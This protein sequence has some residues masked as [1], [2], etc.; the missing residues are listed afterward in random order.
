MCSKWGPCKLQASSRDNLENNIRGGERVNIPRVEENNPTV[1]VSQLNNSP[2]R[3]S[4]DNRSDRSNPL[5]QPP[6]EQ[7]NKQQFP[8]LAK[9]S[10]YFSRRA[11]FNL[12]PKGGES[13]IELNNVTQFKSMTNKGSVAHTDKSF[14][15]STDVD[16]YSLEGLNHDLVDGNRELRVPNGSLNASPLQNSRKPLSRLNIN[17]KDDRLTTGGK[18]CIF[19]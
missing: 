11:A 12:R 18:F 14:L 8:K 17:R 1:A 2:S 10:L 16:E 19:F 5:L 13:D 4:V 7:N 3:L 6:S 9:I 15:A